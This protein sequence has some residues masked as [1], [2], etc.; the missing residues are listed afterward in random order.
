MTVPERPNAPPTAVHPT[1]TRVPARK[2]EVRSKSN[3]NRDNTG[4]RMRNRPIFKCR[5][6]DCARY[7]AARSQSRDLQNICRPLKSH[8]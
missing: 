1:R 8:S 7:T 2:D 5:T 6:E 3:Y 4:P